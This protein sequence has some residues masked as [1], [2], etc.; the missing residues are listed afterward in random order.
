MNPSSNENPGLNLPPPLM[1]QQGAPLPEQTGAVDTT[2]AEQ[3]PLPGPVTSAAPSLPLPSDGAAA[4][5]QQIDDKSTTESV[6]SVTTQHK[7]L[8]DK[9]IVD[10]AKAIIQKTKNDPYKQTEDIT[11]FKAEHLSKNYNKTIKTK[12]SK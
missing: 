11:V 12:P 7:D 8:I 9:D 6:G 5:L 4:I 3:Y 1:E 2:P 10:K